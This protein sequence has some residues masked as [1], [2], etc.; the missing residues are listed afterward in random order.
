[1]CGLAVN[2]NIPETIITGGKG[3]GSNPEKAGHGNQGIGKTTTK[4][5]GGIRAAG[6][7]RTP[8]SC[9]WKSPALGGA[10]S[11]KVD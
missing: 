5:T 2:G 4:V 9:K 3:P 6:S 8:G 11:I 10:L 1:M 7:V